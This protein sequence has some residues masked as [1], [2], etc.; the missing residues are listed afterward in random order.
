LYNLEFAYSSYIFHRAVGKNLLSLIA[1]SL[2]LDEYYFEKIGAL[3]KPVA[4]L[5][6]LHYP[7]LA[8]ILLF[9]HLLAY[10]K[11]YLPC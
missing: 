10:F 9:M 4:V 5:R 6:L 3:N 7:G 11:F 8:F 2:N 1:M